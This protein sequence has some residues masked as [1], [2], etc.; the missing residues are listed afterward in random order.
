MFYKKTARLHTLLDS[1]NHDEWMTDR[2]HKVLADTPGPIP[3]PR[4]W[5][6]MQ[7]TKSYWILRAT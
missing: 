1:A 6:A 4:C 7:T 3:K 2:K 5:A